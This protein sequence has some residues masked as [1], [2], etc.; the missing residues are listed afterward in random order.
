MTLAALVGEKLDHWRIEKWT[1]LHEKTRE[2]GTGKVVG[3]ACSNEN[4]LGLIDGL[5]IWVP[6]TVFVLTNGTLSYV[7]DFDPVEDN[8]SE[9]INLKRKE[10]EEKISTSEITFIKRFC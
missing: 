9:I 4:L 10:I 3:Y 2:G 6:I 5:T 1:A 7:L 8:V